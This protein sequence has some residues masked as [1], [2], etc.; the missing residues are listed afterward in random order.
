MVDLSQ[1]LKWI[2][3]WLIW[4]RHRTIIWWWTIPW[5]RWL[6]LTILSQQT[7]GQNIGVVCGDEKVPNF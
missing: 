7:W 2:D 1:F 5:M 4:W 3:F 6:I